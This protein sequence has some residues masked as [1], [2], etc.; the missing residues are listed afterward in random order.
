M[1]NKLNNNYKITT[2]G[3]QW[4]AYATVVKRTKGINVLRRSKTMLITLRALSRVLTRHFDAYLAALNVSPPQ[5]IILEAIQ[6]SSSKTL[7]ELACELSMH[8]TTLTRNSKRLKEKLYISVKKT[9]DKRQK[10]LTLTEKGCEIINQSQIYFKD[11]EQKL[12]NIL[13]PAFYLELNQKLVGTLN[14]VKKSNHYHL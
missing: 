13:G 3:A 9:N 4:R 12:I 6:A 1:L 8:R 2:G 14:A 11:A 5:L 7:H 10:I